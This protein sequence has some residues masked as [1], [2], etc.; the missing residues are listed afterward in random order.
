MIISIPELSDTLTLGRV[1][2]GLWSDLWS[3][4][5]PENNTELAPAGTGGSRPAPDAINAPGASEPETGGYFASG[6]LPDRLP[7]NFPCTLLLQG[8]LGAGKTTLVRL[9][10]EA[11]PGSERAEV[12]SP[13]FTLC[14]SYAT[15]PEVLHFDLY[16]LEPWQDDDDLADA[17][18]MAENRD[19]LLIIEW[20]ERMKESLLPVDLIYCSLAGE[21]SGRAAAFKTRSAAGRQFLELLGRRAANAGL[22]VKSDD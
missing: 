16:R 18:E 20:P 9:L 8:D 11:L 6:Y 7:E 21:D 10:V 4:A 3:G 2:A 14:N 17:L 22:S 12:S 5:R 1:M 13:S 19:L 15:T